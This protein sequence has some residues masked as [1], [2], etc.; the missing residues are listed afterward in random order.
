MNDEKGSGKGGRKWK[1]RATTWIENGEQRLTGKRGKQKV[2]CVKREGLCG[3][4]IETSAWGSSCRTPAPPSEVSYA[5]RLAICNMWLEFNWIQKTSLS[6]TLSSQWVCAC[7]YVYSTSCKTSLH[8]KKVSHTFCE[9]HVIEQIHTHTHTHTIT[10]WLW[11]PV[12]SFKSTHLCTLWLVHRL[13]MLFLVCSV[14]IL[15]RLSDTKQ[16]QRLCESNVSSM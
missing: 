3:G 15:V 5:W 2:C 16:W 12:N 6:N 4:S 7:V 10:A 11:P 9:V 1:Q 8:K 14:W 13:A